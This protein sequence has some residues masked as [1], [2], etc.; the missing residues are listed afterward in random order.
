MDKES[1][2]TPDIWGIV[3]L[4]GHTKIAG[5][6][7]EVQLYGGVFLRVDVPEVDGRPEFTR[8][9]GAGAIYSITPTT[10]EIARAAAQAIQPKPITVYGMVLPE[11]TLAATS[12]GPDGGSFAERYELWNPPTDPPGEFEGVVETE[13]E[14]TERGDGDDVPF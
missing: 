12:N 3:E 14:E 10:E 13:H 7:L 4:F 11:R 8:L 5:R 2:S 9:Y 1:Q 6:L